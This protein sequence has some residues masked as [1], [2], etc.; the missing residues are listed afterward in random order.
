MA[1]LHALLFVLAASLR[2]GKPALALLLPLP[3]QGYYGLHLSFGAMAL[4]LLALGMMAGLARART[5]RGWRWVHLAWLPALVLISLHGLGI[6]NET[7]FG[8]LRYLYPSMALSLVTVALMRLR[9]ALH[10]GRSV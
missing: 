10:R 2:T 1:F 8:L 7:R 5:S 9:T 3:G 6:G 4:W